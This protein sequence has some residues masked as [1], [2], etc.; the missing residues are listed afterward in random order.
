[1]KHLII[2]LALIIIVVS[3][4][5]CKKNEIDGPSDGLNVKWTRVNAGLTNTLVRCLAINDIKLFAGTD[6]GVFLSTNNGESWNDISNG[7][8]IKSI[9]SIVGIDTNV[10]VGTDSGAFVSTNTGISWSAFNSGLEDV[11]VRALVISDTNIFAGTYRSGIYRS[12]IKVNNW[13]SAKIGLPGSAVQ[14][15]TIAVNGTNLF[16]GIAQG[17]FLSTNNGTSWTPINNGLTEYALKY[18]NCFAFKES[19]IFAG[20]L[21]GVYRSNDH[22]ASW[23]KTS[24]QISNLSGNSFVVVGS[25]IFVGTNGFGGGDS[26]TSSVYLSTDNGSSWIRVGQSYIPGINSLVAN[27]TF[28]FGAAFGGGI[29]R[30]PL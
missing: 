30:C 18:V 22:G 9:Y 3:I 26:N 28:L 15:Y 12:S 7:L 2:F 14:I 8:P 4:H 5:G 17:A 1:M 24:L 27:D 11:R 13:I 21:D 6:N 25:R 23:S 16:A 29:Y 19:Y 20:L 10:F